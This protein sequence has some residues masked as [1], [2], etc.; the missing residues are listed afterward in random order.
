MAAFTPTEY[1]DRLARTRDL[2][3]ARGLTQLA[4][5]DPANIYNL[6]GFDA[7]SFHAPHLLLVDLEQPL[8]LFVREIDAPSAALTTDLDPEQFLTPDGVECLT[9]LPRGLWVHDA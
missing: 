9:D 7:C 8:R 4:V 3:A 5:T 2:L 1:A 6:T